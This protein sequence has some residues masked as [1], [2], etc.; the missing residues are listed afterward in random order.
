VS[1]NVTAI[2]PAADGFITVY[3]CGARPNAS[4]L[5][6]ASHRTVANAVIA[7]VD[8]ATGNVCFFSSQPVHLAVDLNGWFLATAT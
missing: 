7:P 8:P 1:L 2:D 4:S 3:A 6:Y 5:N